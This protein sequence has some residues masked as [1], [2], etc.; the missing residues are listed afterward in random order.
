[1]RL[2]DLQAQVFAIQ[3]AIKQHALSSS[4]DIEAFR[5]RFVSKRGE[6]AQLFSHFKSLSLSDK[7]ALSPLLNT[8]KEQALSRL[9]KSS[10][11]AQSTLTS[12]SSSQATSFQ[13]LSL[14]SLRHPIGTRHPIRQTLQHMISLF[15]NIGF[16]IAE[17]P[18]I[19][20]DWYNFTALHFPPHHPAREMQDT[21]F[22]E[23]NPDILLRTHTSSV[24]VR[25]MEHYSPP[26]RMIMPGTVYRNEAI[27]AR[28]H[29]FFHQ[30]EGI[31]IDQ[32]VSMVDLRNTLI[33][34]VKNMFGEHIKFRFRPSYFPFTEPSAE[35][36]IS[37]TQCKGK[38]CTLCKHSSWL[39][40][41]GCGMIDPQV[42]MNCQIDPKKYSGYAWGIGVERLILLQHGVTDIRLL[43]QNDLRF[44]R[45]FS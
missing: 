36:D 44:L 6:I 4:E 22:L 21:F 34:F 35:L 17:G 32:A 5:L 7:K 43:S 45:Q 13:D 9:K 14:P 18:D 29:C 15:Q 38:G 16:E 26:L 2:E 40:I 1:M 37:C 20:T 11:E 30:L 31:Y 41:A 42:L 19:E 23:K 25:M 28:S 8:L 12:S 3:K 27:T 33:Y 24:Q 10:T 39:E